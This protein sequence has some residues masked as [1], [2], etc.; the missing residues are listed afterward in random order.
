[1]M[2]KFEID[3]TQFTR[4]Q[5]PTMTIKKKAE[6]RNIKLGNYVILMRVARGNKFESKF[7]DKIYKLFT[8]RTR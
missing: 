4:K 3:K 6:K 1:M 2:Q 5:R 8:R 7:Y